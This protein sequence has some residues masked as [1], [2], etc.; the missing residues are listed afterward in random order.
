LLSWCG[1][2]IVTSKRG[3]ACAQGERRLWISIEP[4]MF[5][6]RTV[7]RGRTRRGARA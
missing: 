4:Q 5:A 2:S 1:H 6:V 3:V 7:V